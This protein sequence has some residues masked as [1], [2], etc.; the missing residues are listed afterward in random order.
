[1]NNLTLERC[2]LNNLNLNR[3]LKKVRGSDQ[4]FGG[5]C[6]IFSGDW[7]QTLPII[8]GGSEAQIVHSCL[9]FST[10]WDSV[11]VH[12]LVENMRV[13][14]SGSTE[15]EEHSNWLLQVNTQFE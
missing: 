3:T 7:R 1:M 14:L 6:V 13:Q 4:L 10:I 5:L 2:P 11:T 9:K 12:H 15:A 8:P